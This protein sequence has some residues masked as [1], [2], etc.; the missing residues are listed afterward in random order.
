MANILIG[1]DPEMFLFDKKQNKFIS[2]IDKIGGTKE[3]PKPIGNGCFVQEDNMSV[4]FNT[5]ATDNNKQFKAAINYVKGY[6]NSLYDNVTAEPVATVIFDK[7]ETDDPRAW[8]FGCDPDYSVYTMEEN[9]KPSST[10]KFKRTAGGHIH[11]GYEKGRS[12]A[13]NAEIIKLADLYLGIPS[14][15]MDSDKERREMY[16]KPGAFRHKPYGVEYRTLSNFWIAE[17]TLMDWAFAEAMRVM[18]VVG[19]VKLSDAEHVMCRHA[20]DT[21][22]EKVAAFLVKKY[23]LTVL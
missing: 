4:E 15:F 7:K 5:P 23:Q 11:F 21:N 14:L 20:I 12:Y 6:L 16:G 17:D 19:K 1:I 22:N 10:N 2:A 3:E 13:Q 8:I 18:D 9:K